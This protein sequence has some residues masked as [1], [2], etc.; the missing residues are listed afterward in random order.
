MQTITLP[1]TNHINQT[2]LDNIALSTH[3]NSYSSPPC[4]QKI[5]NLIN[6]LMKDCETSLND[7]NYN[8]VNIKASDDV[9]FLKSKKKTKISLLSYLERLISL[10][11]IEL[12]T[13]IIM[14][15]YFERGVNL[16]KS[17]GVSL[18]EIS[19]YRLILI[20][21]IVSVK[22]SV[23]EHYDNDFYSKA[24]GISL[25]ELNQIEVN[26]LN[27]LNF[28]LNVDIYQFK[29]MEMKYYSIVIDDKAISKLD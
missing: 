7:E 15:I 3:I 9:L 16:V 22:Y 10:C 4:I 18:N 29:Q 19:I 12:N 8:D 20:S 17:S 27:F 28:D 21:M 24:G 1:I 13:A 6:R 26:F 2:H 25:V 14:G 11:E 23:D 5:H